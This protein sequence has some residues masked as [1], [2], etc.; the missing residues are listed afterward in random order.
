MNNKRNTIKLTD[1]KEADKAQVGAKALNLAVMLNAGLPVPEGF[2]VKASVYRKHIRNSGLEKRLEELI[3]NVKGDESIKK[4]LLKEL[5]E[6]IRDISLSGSLIDEVKRQYQNMGSR[7]VAVRSSGTAED[8]PGHSFAGQH[9]TYFVSSL[10]ECLKHI[11]HCWASLWTDRAFEYRERNVFDQ[12]KAEMSVIVQ[13]MVPAEAAGVIFTANPVTLDSNQILIESVFGLGEALV[14]GKVTP[15]QVILDKRDMSVIDFKIA[16]KRVEISQL[17][18]KAENRTVG[19]EKIDKDRVS[20]PSF[21][22]EMAQKLAKIALEAEGIFGEPQDIEWAVHRGEAYIIQSRP[23][24]T[25]KKENNTQ[26]HDEKP[27]KTKRRELWSNVNTGEVLPDVMTPVTWSFIMALADLLFEGL[28]GHTGID[29]GDEKMFEQIAGRAYFNL[30]VMIGAVRKTPGLKDKEI[31]SF[32]GG[33]QGVSFDMD[34]YQLRDEDIPDFK[35]SF[36]KMAIRLPGYIYWFMRHSY[37]RSL[38][39]ISDFERTTERLAKKDLDSLP[40]DELV[41]CLDSSIIAIQ[42]VAVDGIAYEGAG[43]VYFSMLN[44]ACGKWFG[45]EHSTYAN[46]LISGVG[47][48]ESA[49]AGLALWQLAGDAY[50]NLTIR[51]VVEK[52]AG[53]DVVSVELSKTHGGLEYLE[54]WD[55]F[56]SKYGHHTRGEIELYNSRWSEDPDYILNMVRAYLKEIGTIDPLRNYHERI[57]EREALAARCLCDLKNPVRKKLFKFYYTR[58]MHGSVARENIKNGFVRYIAI[59]RGVLL[60]LGSRMAEQGYLK[61]VDDIFFLKL[62]EIDSFPGEMNKFR[63]NEIVRKRRCEYENNLEIIPPPVIVGDFDLKAYTPERLDEDVES[64]SGLAVSP[65][66]VKGPAR[67]ILRTDNDTR[68][69]SGEILVAPFTDPGWTPYFTPAKAI[70]MDMGGMLSHG[71]I[72]AREY[73]IPAV[74]NVGSATKVIK[75]GQMIEVDGNKGVVRILNRD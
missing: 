21:D 8:L 50:D 16:E 32:L 31:G 12:G 4:E 70:V 51:K 35:V 37:K 72:I 60:E 57:K 62:G 17:E 44:K 65:G 54:K 47:G 3:A 34:K 73:G 18:N 19:E 41:E 2:S 71:S 45:D 5:R 63:T 48:M 39:F 7:Q 9:G 66:L 74:V 23:I 15:D 25:F 56:I 30:N 67:V 75:N 36:A 38:D 10:D 1:I 24:T 29:I 46:R 27:E 53:F 68:V 58:A 20:Q 55:E 13:T 42:D 14:S 11:K 59:V 6:E 52:D 43:M 40:D 33:H 28:F 69:R 64:L 49:E 26:S 61:S 22:K